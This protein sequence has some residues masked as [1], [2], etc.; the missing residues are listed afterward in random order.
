MAQILPGRRSPLLLLAAHLMR[1]IDFATCGSRKGSQGGAYNHQSRRQPADRGCRHAMTVRCRRRARSRR[2]SRSFPF[3]AY[4]LLQ[5]VRL[6]FHVHH[7][8]LTGLAV[9]DG[10]QLQCTSIDR[11]A[12]ISNAKKV[13]RNMSNRQSLASSERT[14]CV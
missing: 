8:N 7:R 5:T 3:S 6:R 1:R 10:G 2:R 11:G 12:E 9:Q 4:L 14:K 13:W